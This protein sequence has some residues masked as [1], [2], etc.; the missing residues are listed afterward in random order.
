MFTKISAFGA[1]IL[2]YSSYLA[3]VNCQN[4]CLGVHNYCPGGYKMQSKCVDGSCVCNSQDY[5]Y[6]SCL[7][8]T[9]GCKVSVDA[10]TSLGKP[11]YNNQPRQPT[12]SCTPGSSS[13]SQYEVHVLSVYE[14][15]NRRPPTAGDAT[16]NIFSGKRPDRPLV[17]VLASYEPVNWILKVPSDVTISRVILVAY[18][19][20]KSSVSGDVNQVQAIE[21]KSYRA[22]WPTGYGSDSGGGDTVGLLKKIYE[23]FGV[24]TSF[25]GT[26]KADKWSLS[27]RSSNGSGS[28]IVS[29]S[30]SSANTVITS[31]TPTTTI[32]S[33]SS[34]AKLHRKKCYWWNNGYH[35]SGLYGTK[36][37]VC[38]DGYCVCSFQDYDYHTCLPDTK[39]CK[40][41]VDAATSLGKP[42]Y[43]NQPRQPT[44]SCT[45]GSSSS[46]QYEVHVLSVYE[47]INRRPPTAG[48]AT[49]NIFS[50][51]RSDRPLVLVLASYEPVNW[52]LKLPS[53]VT[54]SRVILVAYYVDKSSVSGDVDQVQAIERKSYRASWPTGF[55]SDSGGGDTVGLLKKIYE[56]FGVVT[57]FTGTYK[58]DKWSLNLR[59]SNGSGSSIVSSSTSSANTVI[60]RT[61]PTTTI[62]STSSTAKLH[63]KTCYW[64]NNGYHCSGLYGTKTAA[65]IDGYCVCS[66]QDYDYHTCLPDT[67]GCKISVDAATSLGKPQYNN[68]LQQPTYSCTPG[69]SSSSQYEVHVLSVYEVINGRP[70]TAADATVNI[71]SGGRLDRPLVLVLASYEPANWILKLPSDVTISR[72]ILVA[73]YVDK[74]SVSGDMNQVQTIERKSYRDSWPIGFGSDSGGGD[75]VGLLK[76]IYE[77]FGVVTSFTGTYRA[78]KW[79]LSLSSSNGLG[80]S[81]V[82]SST[83]SATTVITST[84]STPTTTILSISST[85][86]LHRKKCYWWNNGYHCS[87]LYGTK[88][89]VCIDGYCVCSFQD[90]DYHTC[91]PDTKGCK[92]SVDAATSLG[93]PQYNNQPRQPTYSCTPDSSSSSQYEVHVLSVYEVISR[94]P[95]TAGDATVNIFSGRRPDRP[96][97]LV[98]ANYEPVNWILQIP[99]NITISRVILVAYYV[100]ESSVSGDVNQVLAIERKSYPGSWPRGIGSDSGGGDTVGLLKK[101]YERFGVVTSFTGTY[102][103]DK[104]SLNLSSQSHEKKTKSS[105][106]EVVE[107]LSKRIELL[108]EEVKNHKMKIISL[109]EKR[110]ESFAPQ[111]SSGGPIQK[112]HRNLASIFAITVLTAHIYLVM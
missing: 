34:T 99:S 91:L 95:P 14:V 66:F 84:T 78:D 89:A 86:K 47:V 74:S 97:V 90:Y 2:F 39:G 8:D 19:V 10:A 64:W 4:K 13:S 68:Q 56:K 42:Q 50:G 94:R 44:Y 27:L 73:Y 18:Y 60:T 98:L 53:D 106:H 23:K 57:S 102:R 85:A 80:S 5:N 26:Y 100:D 71:F 112:I 109:K 76:K 43:N 58:A 111:I 51:G 82:S 103:A 38:I 17:L 93:K 29:S 22:S 61:T 83:S 45:P 87:G 54:I 77:K 63:R 20:D 16:V 79:S 9:K 3:R 67:K 12:Y 40:I 55:G 7:P 110:D 59:S 62:P 36:T 48:D 108:S 69:S 30:K 52:I 96:L 104:W 41:S 33:T 37:A 105:C 107:K 46:S 15:I 72:V 35:C 1:L 101:I 21:R 11:Q 24:V 70:P 65:C 92:I 81:I 49:V 28:S 25:T 6:H 75:T 32:P 88:T 31:T